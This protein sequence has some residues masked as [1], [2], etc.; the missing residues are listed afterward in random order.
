MI[1]CPRWFMKWIQ[2]AWLSLINIYDVCEF[3]VISLDHTIRLELIGI[4]TLIITGYC[5]PHFFFFY[6]KRQLHSLVI[7]MS[8]SNWR[9]AKS[10]LPWTL[11]LPSGNGRVH[12]K[13]CKWPRIR[14]HSKN[15]SC[16]CKVGLYF[17]LNSLIPAPL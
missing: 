14:T 12:L 10:S 2:I 11:Q 4:L 7:K 1:R 6:F 5:P 17:F 15:A 16:T 8:D 9:R 13:S 3:R